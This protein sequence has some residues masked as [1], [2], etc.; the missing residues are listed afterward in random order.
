MLVV[1]LARPKSPPGLLH[2]SVLNMRKF[3]VASPEVAGDPVPLPFDDPSPQAANNGRNS[4]FAA[5]AGPIFVCVT[6][7]ETDRITEPAGMP[8]DAMSNSISARRMFPPLVTPENKP[9]VA[10]L[11]PLSL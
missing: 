7:N 9:P 4:K 5:P 3:H 8:P 1:A 2:E 6:D 10:L 11:L